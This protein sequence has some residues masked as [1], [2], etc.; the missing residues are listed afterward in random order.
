MEWHHV[1]SPKND[2]RTVALA[3]KVMQLCSE[4]GTDAERLICI[5]CIEEKP[6]LLL[7]TFICFRNCNVHLA[8]RTQWIPR[9]IGAEVQ[10]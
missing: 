6:V 8:T 1:I 4:I 2:A 5:F 10:S 9:D 3:S 7:A